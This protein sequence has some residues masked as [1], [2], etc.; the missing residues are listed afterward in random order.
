MYN[1]WVSQLE[2]AV[3]YGNTFAVKCFVLVFSDSCGI[4][5]CT[6]AIF[7]IDNVS[8]MIVVS[9]AV[10]WANNRESITTDNYHQSMMYQL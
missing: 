10:N 5:K 4:K 3:C 8:V 1:D 7:Y 2:R 9:C 6:Y